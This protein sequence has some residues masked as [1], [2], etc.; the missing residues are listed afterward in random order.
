MVA[1]L[2]HEVNQPLAAIGNYLQAGQRL[3]AAGN[4]ALLPAAL[5]KARREATRASEI[6]RR[7]RDHLKKQESVRRPENLVAMLQE[8]VALALVGVRR[9]V[10]VDLRPSPAGAVILIDRIQIQQ[11]LM[12]LIRNAVEAAA[13]RPGLSLT[14]LAAPAAGGMIELSVADDGPGLEPQVRERLFQPFVT[15]KP[16]GMGVGLS[17]CQAIVEAHGGRI[18]AEDRPGGGTVFRFTVP[19]AG[20]GAAGAAR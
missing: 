12:N 9:E 10:Q 18:W 3:A 6:V 2:A 11:V 7:L 8:T 20:G 14:I 17:I 13:D 16:E 4:M 19:T 1:A 5:E 15:T